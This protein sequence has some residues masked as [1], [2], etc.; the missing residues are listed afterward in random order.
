MTETL[1]GRG[2][3]F[4]GQKFIADVHYEMDIIQQYGTTR[5]NTSEG[6]YSNGRVVRLFIS[7]ASAI[8]VFGMGTDPLTLLMEDGRKQKFF[9]SSDGNCV[10]TG[11]P[12]E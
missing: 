11:G 2:K 3:I 1:S 5:T 10:A 7:P 12:H 6:P 4:N 9:P 8:C